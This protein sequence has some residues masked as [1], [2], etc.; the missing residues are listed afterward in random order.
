MVKS[1]EKSAHT[2]YSSVTEHSSSTS[3]PLHNGSWDKKLHTTVQM[4]RREDGGTVQVKEQVK[5]I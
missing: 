5:W 4:I 3:R 1:Q 2:H